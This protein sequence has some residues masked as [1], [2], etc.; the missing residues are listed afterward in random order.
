MPRTAAPPTDALLLG[1]REALG[2]S[3]LMG[4]SAIRHCGRAHAIAV[5]G[6]F[7]PDYASVLE[8]AGYVV[9]RSAGWLTVSERL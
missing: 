4:W 9:E 2:E 1:V 8:R 3:W 5:R 7:L 6:V